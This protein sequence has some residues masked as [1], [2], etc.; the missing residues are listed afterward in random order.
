MTVDNRSRRG[1][2][3]IARSS[4]LVFVVIA[5]LV[6]VVLD[7]APDGELRGVNLFEL[8]PRFEWLTML[9]PMPLF[10]VAS[11][12]ANAGGNRVSRTR[13]ATVLVALATVVAVGW[14]IA[15][16]A[17]RLVTGANGIVSDGSR[18]ATQPLWFLTAWV[19]FTVFAGLLDRMAR[20]I[21]PAVAS[22][23]TIM[24][25]TDAVRFAGGAPRWVGYP[26]FF[27][28]WAV[29]WLMGSW[30]RRRHESSQLGERRT[31]L[32]I[33]TMSTIVAGL[34]VVRFGYHAAL[35]DAV[36][37]HRSNT[38]PP[39]LFTA[40][41][42]LIQVGLFMIAAR[43]LDMLAIRRERAIRSL[44]AIAPGL[45]VW[46]LTALSLCGAALAAGLWAPRRLSTGWWLSRP[47][48]FLAIVG[49]SIVLSLATRK[50][51]APMQSSPVTADLRGRRIV[52]VATI[53]AAVAFGLTGLFGPDTTGMAVAI[54]GLCIAASTAFNFATRATDATAPA[55]RSTS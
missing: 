48:W 36:P 32:G 26:G 4:A 51:L 50:A 42:S 54:A 7:R 41:A 12:W 34:L 29:P 13:R 18:I 52:G 37:G 44:D 40:V 35:I 22:C 8:Y 45:Y 14:C 49:L 3:D 2:I 39:T 11:G 33:A 28:A 27:A 15:A 25:V 1:A 23:L 16:I 47:L 9:S 17:E 31:G 5:H 19:P 43:R 21:V 53:S 6:M 30:W 38:T 55:G 10:F 20:R 24:V 46:H